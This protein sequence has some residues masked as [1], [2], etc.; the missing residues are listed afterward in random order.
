MSA[1]TPAVAAMRWKT[2]MNENAKMHAFSHAFPEL[3]HNE[4]VGWGSAGEFARFSAVFRSLTARFSAFLRAFA[5]RF[6]QFCVRSD[7]CA[8]SAAPAPI[9]PASEKRCL[10]CKKWASR[11]SASRTGST[12]AWST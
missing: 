9:E 5:A 8:E 1:S 3:G 2:Q 10:N 4:I 7:A 12:P 11:P 6:A